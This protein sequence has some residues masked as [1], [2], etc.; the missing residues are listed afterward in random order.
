MTGSPASGATLHDA[1][2]RAERWLL[3][4]V[5]LLWVAWSLPLALQVSTLYTRD[6]FTVHLPAKAFG[7][8]ELRAGRIPATRPDWGLGQPWRGNPNVLPLYPGNLL[9]LALPFFVA[10]NLHYALHWLLAL[11]AMRALARGLGLAEAPALIAGLTYAGSGFLWSALSFYNLV[12]VAAWWPLALLGGVRSDRRGLALGG[13]ACGLALLA[14]DPLLAAL[15]LAPLL[16]LCVGRHGARRGLLR[17]G[18]IGALGLSLALPQAVA[19]LRVVGFAERTTIDEASALYSLH[20]VRLLELLAPLPF[21]V[22]DQLGPERFLT[23]R[24]GPDVPFVLSLHA[25]IVGLALALVVLRR[26]RALAALAGGGLLLAAMGPALGAALGEA[27]GGLFRY[28]E[29][30]LFWTAL[31]LP[32]LAAHGLAALESRQRALRITLLFLAAGCALLAI[33]TVLF[34]RA[35][36][37]WLAP[38]LGAAE[39]EA[40]APVRLRGAALGLAVSAALATA[41]LPAVRARSALALCALQLVAVLRLLPT[42]PTDEV[43]PYL[44]APPFAAVLAAAGP[45]PTAPPGVLSATYDSPFAEPAPVY[46]VPSASRRT[47]R[48]I[49][50]LDLDYPT[51]P[52]HGWA[53]PL[54]DAQEGLGSPLLALL[55]RA[56]PRM[57]WP[58][59]TAWLS[60]LGVEAVTLVARAPPPGLALT[61]GDDRFGVP[62]GL[63]RVTA[64]DGRAGPPAEAWWPEE[65][66][67]EP[68]AGA[69]LE[70]VAGLADPAATVIAPRDLDH[71]PARVLRV[72]STPDRVTVEVEGGGGLLA[73][74]RAY[75]PLWR[76]RLAASGEPLP[77]LPVD[78]LLLGVEVPPGRHRVE[79][80]ISSRPERLAAWGTLVSLLACVWLA[81]RPSPGAAR[82]RVAIG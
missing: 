43:D 17:A 64:T 34:G 62:T 5:V 23:G 25:G 69:T 73:I 44:Q 70:A 35:T 60:A 11:F 67:F 24:L 48:R 68:S 51:A 66:R 30:L 45:A 9:Y 28:P 78:L 53:A 81:R 40:L 2:R 55:R 10:F 41:A 32:L 63:Y 20:P 79:L 14:G 22:P 26:Q 33:A 16:V 21:G 29:K 4:A 27:T 12:A 7:A 19:T 72:E 82:D 39:L 15:G 50:H 3:V 31:A 77:T 80:E 38:D 8:A 18:A 1:S 36:I 47:F 37:A 58:E 56:L 76:A 57:D 42:A 13:V 54:G 52:L 46:A 74:R 6:V 49:G 71:R 59:R 75:L 65:V 61:A